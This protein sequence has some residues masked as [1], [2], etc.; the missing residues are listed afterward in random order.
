MKDI[1]DE[2]LTLIS[3]S[4]CN[5]LNP[6][7]IFCIRWLGDIFLDIILERMKEYDIKSSLVTLL[8]MRRT[9]L[10][11]KGLV[12]SKDIGIFGGKWRGILFS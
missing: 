4:D 1:I 11:T 8:E 2:S 3:N 5:H 7:L 10:I 12:E 6:H 9:H